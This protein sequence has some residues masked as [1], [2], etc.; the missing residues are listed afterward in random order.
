MAESEIS[1]NVAP[2]QRLEAEKLEHAVLQRDI[3][4][5]RLHTSFCGRGIFFAVWLQRCACY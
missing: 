3:V 1:L 2:S 5:N 4:L